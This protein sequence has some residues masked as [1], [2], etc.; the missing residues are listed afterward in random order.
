MSF[1]CLTSLSRS[2][3]VSVC[4]SSA[5]SAS[6]SG[7]QARDTFLPPQRLSLVG[8]LAAE[9][10]RQVFLRVDMLVKSVYI[11]TSAKN[12]LSDASALTSYSLPKKR[13]ASWCTSSVSMPISTPPVADQFLGL[14]PD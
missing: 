2:G 8:N 14:L 13:L 6:Y 7:L 12:R 1:S 11:C 9:L 5:Y 4:D 10:T 3:P